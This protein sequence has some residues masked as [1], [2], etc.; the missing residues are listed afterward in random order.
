MRTQPTIDPLWPGQPCARGAAW[1]GMG[2]NFAL[3]S[4]SAERVELCL[5]DR[6][7]REEVARL[8]SREQTDQVFLGYL[9]RCKVVESAFTW[10]DDQPPNVPWHETVIYE[11]H[12]RGFTHLHL[13]L[14]PALRGT[15]AGL[16]CAPVVEYFKRQGV[17]TIELMPV[18][19]F[20]DDRRLLE[21]GLR[22][23]WGY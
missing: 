17:T 7:G 3:F 6:S 8:A 9:P 12:V 16:A 18:H 2:V 22:N 10:G 11:L 23:Y 13:E 15:Y 1:D 21:R 20:V 5:F 19:S 4:E 14:P